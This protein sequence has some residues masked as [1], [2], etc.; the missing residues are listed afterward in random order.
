MTPEERILKIVLQIRNK[1]WWTRQWKTARGGTTTPVVMK[2]VPVR[3]IAAA[4]ADAGG[5]KRTTGDATGVTLRE[6]ASSSVRDERPDDER[7]GDDA[8][9]YTTPK[10]KIIPPKKF[11]SAADMTTLEIKAAAAAKRA[12]IP[13]RIQ[14]MKGPQPPKVNNYATESGNPPQTA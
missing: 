12:E 6:S 13:P 14:E 8:E 10:S 2:E 4:D 7:F 1:M 11:M 5:W 9:Y 3:Y